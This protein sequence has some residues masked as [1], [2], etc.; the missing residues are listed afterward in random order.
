MQA[1]LKENRA[2]KLFII[3]LLLGLFISQKVKHN[4]Y[5]KNGFVHQPSYLLG[6][7]INFSLVG[8]N[9]SESSVKISSLTSDE[10]FEVKIFPYNTT[11]IKDPLLFGVGKLSIN[12]ISSKDLQSGIYLINDTIPFVIKDPDVKADIIVV[13]PYANNLIETPFNKK[14]VKSQKYVYTSF[15]R[16]NFIDPITLGGASFFKELEKK[17]TVKYISDTDMEDANNIKG[18]QLLIIY[19]NMLYSSSKM[20]GNVLDFIKTGGNVLLA[21]EEFMNNV[22]TINHESNELVL[23]NKAKSNGEY[24]RERFAESLGEIEGVFISEV[25]GLSYS[26]G[27]QSKMNSGYKVLSGSALFSDLDMKNVPVLGETYMG[28]NVTK[29]KDTFRCNTTAVHEAK[30][31]A[32]IDTEFHGNKTVSGIIE[33]QVFENGGKIMSLGTSQWFSNMNYGE[34]AEI[35]SVTSNVI[36][37]LLND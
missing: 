21:A 34:S 7:D 4:Q 13:Y 35:R 9:T 22:F 3:L 23:N 30:V 33:V 24:T 15:L 17:Y 12:K 10:T 25:I 18:V 32:Y 36:S 29:E 20:K 26:K 2:L 19:Q 5:Q 31:H 14:A 1:L 27:G 6:Y 37:Y 8:E 16:S 11:E 28:L